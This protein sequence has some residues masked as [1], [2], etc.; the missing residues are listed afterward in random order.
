MEQRIYTDL[1]THTRLSDG[2]LSPDELIEE[3]KKAG[4][5]ALAI[6]DHNLD[7]EDYEGL[8]AK[9]PDMELIRGS[10]ISCFYRT[11][12][13]EDKELH[14][15][16]LDYDPENVLMKQ[17]FRKNAYDR[18]P[19]VEA[20]LAK[21][22][23]NGI[24][25]GSYET[26]KAAHPETHHLGRKQIADTM[27]EQGYTKTV[28]EGF[29]IYIGNFGERRAYVKNPF[30]YASLEEVVKA[31]IAAKG[32]PVL[33]HLF[34]YG[35]SEEENRE[36]LEHFSSITGG[37]GAMEVEYGRYTRSQRDE[38][39]KYAAEY[40]L[41]ESAA[42]DFHGQSETQSLENGF[43][44]EIYEKMKEQRKWYYGL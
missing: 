32:V 30:T 28:D 7:C 3:A 15:V 25:L 38:L 31:I 35:L 37:I 41:M 29:D 1:H 44:Y 43:P 9:H 21:L 40:G 20:I 13:G 5:R 4:I 8:S 12:S 42:S 26:L 27:K 23:E 6:T 10:E 14:V 33:A 18:K 24:D 17:I 2:M 39:K 16:A 19:Y 34:Y 36:L 22:R 11:S